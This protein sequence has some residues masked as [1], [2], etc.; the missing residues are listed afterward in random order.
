MKHIEVIL[1]TAQ[2]ET[3]KPVAG[4][5]ACRKWAMREHYNSLVYLTNF[6][7]CLFPLFNFTEINDSVKYG[8]ITK[9]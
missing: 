1:Y 7:S 9:V 3:V 6:S 2:V 8:N 4:T 5:T